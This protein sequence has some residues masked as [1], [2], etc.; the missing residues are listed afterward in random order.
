MLQADTPHYTAPESGKLIWAVQFHPEHA[1]GPED[2]N[3]MFTDYVEEVVKYRER[4][5]ATVAS[6]LDASLTA[7]APVSSTG[8]PYTDVVV[9]STA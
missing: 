8:V 7:A 1:G 2:C 3:T 4:A 5:N 9:P 6:G